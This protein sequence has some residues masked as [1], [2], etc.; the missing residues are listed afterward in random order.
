MQ[1]RAAETRDAQP[2]HRKLGTVSGVPVSRYVVHAAWL[3]PLDLARHAPALLNA[4]L[5]RLNGSKCAAFAAARYLA[6]PDA[7]V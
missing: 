6:S 4:R 2:A 3:L 5:V 7:M 1:K